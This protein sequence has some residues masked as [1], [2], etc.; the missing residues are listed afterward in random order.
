MVDK[1]NRLCKDTSAESSPLQK[2]G[3]QSLPYPGQAAMPGASGRPDYCS[4]NRVTE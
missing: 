4:M 3:L 2:H 1:Y